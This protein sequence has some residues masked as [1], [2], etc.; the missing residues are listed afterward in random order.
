MAGV[1][2]VTVSLRR[3]ISIKIREEGEDGGKGI[4]GGWRK[5]EDGLF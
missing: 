3:S 5:G 1:G 4:R 2:W